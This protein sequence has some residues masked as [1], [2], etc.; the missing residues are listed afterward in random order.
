MTNGEMHAAAA[1]QQLPHILTEIVNV[2]GEIRDKLGAPPV[3]ARDLA[4]PE[5]IETEPLAETSG[6][7]RSADEILRTSNRSKREAFEVFAKLPS[8]E[9]FQNDSAFRLKMEMLGVR[10]PA[11]LRNKGQ[12]FTDRL[13]TLVVCGLVSSGGRWYKKRFVP[14]S[15]AAEIIAKS[16]PWKTKGAK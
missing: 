3:E 10:P 7:E 6:M 16:V 9:E 2:L 5:P 8:G 12:F 4:A 11:Y 1:I 13:K 15:E 14:D